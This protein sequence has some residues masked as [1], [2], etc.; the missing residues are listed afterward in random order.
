MLFLINFG[1]GT[2]LLRSLWLGVGEIILGVVIGVAL[3]RRI[4]NEKCFPEGEKV[5]EAAGVP[6]YELAERR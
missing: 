6:E 4:A 1:V 3:V 5:A 2:L